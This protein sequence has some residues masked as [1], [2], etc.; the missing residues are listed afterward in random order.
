MKN[1][2]LITFILL[3]IFT[4][5]GNNS[6]TGKF[7]D[8]PVQGLNY[9]CL[10]SGITGVTNSDGEYTCNSGDRVSFSLGNISLGTHD[11]QTGALIPYDFFPNNHDAAVN[12]A[13]LLQSVDSNPSDDVIT[14]RDDLVNAIPSNINFKDDQTTFE[15][16]IMNS[17]MIIDSTYD[18]PSAI[19][20]K[21]NMDIAISLFGRETPIQGHDPIAKAG[22]F[23]NVATFST[24]ILDGS[25]SSDIDNDSLTYKW[26]LLSIPDSSEAKLSDST[27]VNPSFVADVDGLYIAQL[28]VNDGTVSSEADKVNIV[29]TTQIT[30]VASFSY[31]DCL[32]ESSLKSPED[33]EDSDAHHITLVNNSTSA[34]TMF[35]VDE[36]GERNQYATIEPGSSVSQ[37]TFPLDV[38]VIADENGVCQNIF[39]SNNSDN[40]SLAFNDEEEFSQ[41]KFTNAATI[42][43]PENETS[44]LTLDTS[45]ANGVV[46]Y[47]LKNTADG[48]S[49]SIDST[50]G[51]ISFKTAPDF[52][53]KNIYNI[54][55]SANDTISTISQS[56]V[57]NIS[58]ISETGSCIPFDEIGFNSDVISMIPTSILDKSPSLDSQYTE[59]GFEVRKCG[60]LT[61]Y[62]QKELN[63]PVRALLHISGDVQPSVVSPM[64]EKIDKSIISDTIIYF[65]APNYGVDSGKNKNGDTITWPADL[66]KVI[67]RTYD[68]SGLG[69]LSLK[70]GTHITGLVTLNGI[71]AISLDTMNYP[72]SNIILTSGFETASVSWQSVGDARASVDDE[73]SFSSNLSPSLYIELAH[74]GLWKDSAGIE[75]LDLIDSTVYLDE[76]LNFGFWGTGDFKTNPVAMFYNGPLILSADPKDYLGAQVGFGAENITLKNYIDF[77]IAYKKRHSY[78]AGKAVGVDSLDDSTFSA[79]LNTSLDVLPLDVLKLK[80]SNISS[81]AFKSGDSFPSLKYFNLIALGPLATSNDETNGPLVKILGDAY[82]LNEKFGDIDFT[83]SASGMSGSVNG[84]LGF[85]LGSFAGV[86]LGNI[87]G[88]MQLNINSNNNQESMTLSGTIQSGPFSFVPLTLNLKN[89]QINY[90]LP[91]D[92]ALPFS[93]NS[94]AN[95]SQI[96]S[97]SDLARQW[98]LSGGRFDMPEP[99]ALL[100]CSG[101]LYGMIKDTIIHLAGPA[102]EYIEMGADLLPT[103]LAGIANE[104]TGFVFNTATDVI[105][106][107]PLKELP[108]GDLGSEFNSVAGPVVQAILDNEAAALAAEAARLAAEAARAAEAAINAGL[109]QLN[110]FV[111]NPLG[112][113]S[114]IGKAIGNLASSATCIFGCGS[115]GPAGFGWHGPYLPIKAID[116]SA[117]HQG[118]N[119]LIAEDG[120]PLQVDNLGN[121][122]YNFWYRNNGLPWDFPG[123]VRIDSDD[124][125]HA[126]AID[127]KGRLW[128]YNGYWRLTIHYATDVGIGGGYIWITSTED[129]IYGTG[130]KIYR[131]SYTPGQTSYNFEFMHGQGTKIDV[132]G[133]GRAW[134]LNNLFEIYEWNYGWYRRGEL[135]LDLTVSAKNRV[136]IVSAGNYNKVNGGGRIY[137]YEH[138]TKGF[139]GQ[140]IN[141][142]PFWEETAGSAHAIGAGE[143]RIV[144]VTNSNNDV[145][146]GTGRE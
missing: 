140:C 92:C 117:G 142:I 9:S 65:T 39:T 95:I 47:S 59:A 34:I 128:T 35:W 21:A 137:T 119:W 19:D 79:W 68:D 101:E 136:W 124:N 16:Q 127:R 1:L 57:L 14:L 109:T 97:L 52:E 32:Q 46:S 111:N 133:D 118:D 30:K 6:I 40:K 84:D 83:G 120:Y 49:F 98:Q 24:V 3:F 17:L 5:C 102:G 99:G 11:V 134:V 4:G 126:A 41:F 60:G 90:Y 72:S 43:T 115:N 105:N 103:P 53:T 135:A 100:S 62:M 75:G 36:F 7:V 38:W 77:F 107:T 63:T 74:S 146:V 139:T 123:F 48:A 22:S 55:V 145:F 18:M 73:N 122:R 51:V 61:L 110:N 132:G 66:K 114:N 116:V 82:F 15:Q 113:L 33:V 143:G 144:W 131:A 54:E 138:C 88:N 81:L 80:N 112:T 64:L 25:N 91:A 42:K 106:S 8:D 23:Q 130:Y 50:S 94:Y 121:A 37:E 67:D 125:G 108:L 28:I 56:I 129:W 86:N 20:A 70:E 69:A 76:S 10:P 96:N 85:S 58:D 45:G 104:A 89:N 87:G 29:A 44:A 13:R 78:L 27:I 141:N 12:M 93:V 26:S 71:L 31:Y 2:T